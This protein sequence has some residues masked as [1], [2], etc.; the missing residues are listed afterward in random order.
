VLVEKRLN[1]AAVSFSIPSRMELLTEDNV[2]IRLHR[3]R[4]MMRGWL[5]ARVGTEAKSA[6]PFMGTRCDRVVHGVLARLSEPS[7]D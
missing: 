5:Y 1:L 7:N 4:A 2:K 6:F 3:G